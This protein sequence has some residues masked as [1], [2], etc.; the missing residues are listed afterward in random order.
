[1]VVSE[2]TGRGRYGEGRPGFYA[3]ETNSLAQVAWKDSACTPPL[4]WPVIVYICIHNMFIFG[5]SF[6]PT[7]FEA[8]GRR[9]QDFIE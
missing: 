9:C 3:G 6:A 2:R 1:M 8:D 4:M 5:T 7:V